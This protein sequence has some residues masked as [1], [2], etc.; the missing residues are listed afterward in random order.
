M[1]S[2]LF[3]DGFLICLMT[4]CGFIQ[5]AVLLR[6]DLKNR[7]PKNNNRGGGENRQ[8]DAPPHG[9]GNH[10]HTGPRRSVP[11][12]LPLS[13]FDHNVREPVKS[14]NRV[15]SSALQRHYPPPPRSPRPPLFSDIKMRHS[16]T[17]NGFNTFD[18]FCSFFLF[19]FFFLSAVLSN[20]RFET[21]LIAIL[22]RFCCAFLK[23]L[24]TNKKY[25]LGVFPSGTTRV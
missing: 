19:F 16:C 20:F 3:F 13:S 1:R 21:H 5:L 11:S 22:K 18:P 25:V 23:R 9:G 14:V 10:H 17:G 7:I 6:S 24:V 12:A 4:R 2:S 8:M 15:S